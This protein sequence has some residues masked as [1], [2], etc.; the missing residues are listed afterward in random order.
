M[1]PNANLETVMAFQTNQALI[2]KEQA[3]LKAIKDNPDIWT[4]PSDQFQTV[5]DN[6]DRY[7]EWK[8]KPAVIDGDP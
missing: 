6:I 7:F 2:T 4:H 8:E 1:I 3:F 5:L